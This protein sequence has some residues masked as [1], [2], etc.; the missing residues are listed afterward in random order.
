MF[1]CLL[2]LL[3]AVLFSG[4]LFTQNSEEAFCILFKS[5][6]KVFSLSVFTV[7]IDG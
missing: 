1:D 6:F 3:V 5:A 4:Y 2:I 7:H